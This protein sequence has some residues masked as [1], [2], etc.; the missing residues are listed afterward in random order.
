MYTLLCINF[1]NM[2]QYKQFNIQDSHGLACRQPPPFENE[3]AHPTLGITKESPS[4]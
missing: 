1:E 2:D 4:F 3:V